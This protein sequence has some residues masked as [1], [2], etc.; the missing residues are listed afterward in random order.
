M[1][2]SRKGRGLFYVH[3]LETTMHVIRDP[4]STAQIN[5]LSIRRLVEQRIFDLGKEPFDLA[6]LGYFIIVEP[7]DSITTIDAQ[8]GFP[9]LANRFTG[10]RFSH[11][12]F[13]PS[14]EF[15]EEFSGC[16]AMVFILDDSGFGIEVFVP[17]AADI[18]S[19]LLMMCQLYST[20]GAVTSADI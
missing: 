20:P 13:S 17:K 15:V 6:V 7:G 16:F 18:D 4:S 10:I 8:L 19:D 11:P 14:F 3:L 5:D 9:I 1:P 2:A 12:G